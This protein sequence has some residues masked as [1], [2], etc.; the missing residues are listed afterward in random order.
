MRFLFAA[1]YLLLTSQ[2]SFALI[3][4]N[5]DRIDINELSHPTI[6]KI[7]TSV[8]SFV[9]K[10]HLKKNRD[11]YEMDATNLHKRLNFCEDERF[12]NEPLFANCSGAII[13]DDLILTAGHCINTQNKDE[14]YVVLDYIKDP[15]GN[16]PS[17]FSKDQVFEV[18]DFLYHEFSLTDKVNDLAVLRVKRDLNRIAL[19]MNLNHEYSHGTP[20]YMLGHPL[21]VSQKYTGPNIIRSLNR[22]TLS[23]RTELDSFSVNSGSPI[24]DHYSH[25][26]IGV[27]SRGTGSNFEKRGRDC[28]QW[29]LGEAG[30]DFSDVNLLTPIKSS[31]L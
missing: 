9:R 12:S 1:I 16:I 14:F 25:E 22:E 2:K 20:I 11:S 4:G 21:G 29:S 3:I 15:L 26:I 24:F 7:S 23:F 19:E 18:K 10:K 17:A 27:L 13:G 28:Y 6:S 30:R 8:V 31:N 5:D